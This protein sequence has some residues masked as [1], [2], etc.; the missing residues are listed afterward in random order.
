MKRTGTYGMMAEFD[1]VHTLLDCGQP[2]PRSR[3]QEDRRL[4]PVPH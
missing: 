1:S 3:L 4:Q 2:H